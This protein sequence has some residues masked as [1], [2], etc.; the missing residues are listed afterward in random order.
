MHLLTRCVCFSP[1]ESISVSLLLSGRHFVD[2]ILNMPL[3][4]KSSN[5][6]PQMA[7]GEPGGTLKQ[8]YSEHNTQT[9]EW[10][11]AIIND[12]TEV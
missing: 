2:S 10:Q 9:A 11:A 7:G 12:G 1:L 3:I 8:Q 5:R 4:R 6:S